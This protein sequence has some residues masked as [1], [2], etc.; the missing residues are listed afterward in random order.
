MRRSASS[1]ISRLVEVAR[2]ITSMAITEKTSAV[3]GASCPRDANKILPFLNCF[4]SVLYTAQWLSHLR[5]PA[6]SNVSACSDKRLGHPVQRAVCVPIRPRGRVAGGTWRSQRR[7][8]FISR[9]RVSMQKGRRQEVHVARLQFGQLHTQIHF[10]DRLGVGF[11]EQSQKVRKV[12][13]LFVFDHVG[14]GNTG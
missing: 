8:E 2:C 14:A 13:M 10:N 1:F 11:A 3:H 4:N 5:E 7:I 12:V 6:S 9:A